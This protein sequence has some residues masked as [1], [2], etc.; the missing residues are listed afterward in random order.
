MANVQADPADA[1]ETFPQAKEKPAATT[2]PVDFSKGCDEP[3]RN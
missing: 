1:A 3:G 2:G